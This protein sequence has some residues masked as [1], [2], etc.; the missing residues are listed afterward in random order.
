MSENTERRA[1]NRLEFPSAEVFYKSLKRFNLISTLTGP[2][3]LVNISKSGACFIANNSMAKGSEVILKIFLP[4]RDPFSVKANTVWSSL[5]HENR[6]TSVGV[7][8]KP[9]GEGK[10][11]NSFKL[12]EMLEQIYTTNANKN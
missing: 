3:N 1:L 2:T 12:K 8:F 7:Q 11:Y 5:N 6:Q 10:G 9:F 4:E